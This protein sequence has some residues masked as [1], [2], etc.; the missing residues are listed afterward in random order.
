MGASPVC[1]QHRKRA[2]Y[3]FCDSELI[4]NFDFLS[5]RWSLFLCCQLSRKERSTRFNLS[6]QISTKQR[7]TSL[8]FGW[9]D[10]F[11]ILSVYCKCVNVRIILRFTVGF[12]IRVGDILYLGE[13]WSACTSFFSWDTSVLFGCLGFFL[14]GRRCEQDS[15][16]PF[17]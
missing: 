17:E 4:G 10:E 2:I 5:P 7:E 14:L 13:D 15:V 12:G 11:Q 9:L 6:I 1:T 3:A 8:F 16:Q